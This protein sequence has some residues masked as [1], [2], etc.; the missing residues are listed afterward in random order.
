MVHVL[1]VAFESAEDYWRILYEDVSALRVKEVDEALTETYA[2]H[3]HFVV[4]VAAT[5]LITVKS[6]WHSLDE[7]H[8]VRII[9]AGT[10]LVELCKFLPF[11]FLLFDVITILSQ[12]E[13]LYLGNPRRVNTF[14]QWQ[15]LL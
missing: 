12:Q 10:E 8:E 2:F 1:N 6:F 5:Q 7:P 13:F 15:E 4:N 9:L 3:L 11:F 14:H